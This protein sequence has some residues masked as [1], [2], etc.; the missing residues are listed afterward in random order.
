VIFEKVESSFSL[1][2]S[3]MN[4]DISLAVLCIA[5]N[6]VG[7]GKWNEPTFEYFSPNTWVQF[8]IN[9]ELNNKHHRQRDQHVRKQE[10]SISCRR[11]GIFPRVLRR[12]TRREDFVAHETNDVLWTNRVEAHVLL[13]AAQQSCDLSAFKDETVSILGR[14]MFSSPGVSGLPLILHE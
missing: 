12:N 3:R 9:G 13:F 2:Y 8:D 5:T 6:L 10:R 14:S 7:D 11:H 4:S 1:F